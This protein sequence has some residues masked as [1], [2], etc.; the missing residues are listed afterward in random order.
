LPA[1]VQAIIGKPHAESERAVKNLEAE[2]FK[3]ANMVDIFD[4][5]PVLSCPRDEI[6][7][8]RA[9]R[10]ETISAVVEREIESSKFLLGTTAENFRACCTRVEY[11]PGEGLTIPAT[12]A[13][14]LQVN[15]GDAIRFVELDAS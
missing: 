7:S 10:R 11:H 4:A 3:F 6:R 1:Q 8:V 13:K 12:A 14:A 15:V 5:G 9:S 2:G